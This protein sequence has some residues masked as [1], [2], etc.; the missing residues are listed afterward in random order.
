[1]TS[2]RAIIPDKNDGPQDE[3]MRVV[4]LSFSRLA[5]RNKPLIDI[6]QDLTIMNSQMAVR[7]SIIMN[8]MVSMCVSENRPIPENFMNQTFLYQAFNWR[9]AT[10]LQGIK[11]DTLR[12]AVS[13]RYAYHN[14]DHGVVHPEERFEPPTRILDGQEWLLGYLAGMYAAN[15]TTSIKGK[16]RSV[17]N[18]SIKTYGMTHDL[19]SHDPMLKEIKRQ[20]YNPSRQ[21]PATAPETLPNDAIDLIE[22]HRNGFCMD[23]NDNSP[24]NDEYFENRK[25]Y[26]HFVF[27][28]GRCLERQCELE[29]IHG[30][31]FKKVHPLPMFGM[32]NCV[33]LQID[34]KGMYY[35]LREFERYHRAHGSL[36]LYQQLFAYCLP[37]SKSSFTVEMFAAWVDQLF[38][39]EEVVNGKKQFH[40]KGVI[41]TTDA[42]QVSVHYMK[43]IPPNPNAK[44]KVITNPRAIINAKQRSQRMVRIGMSQTRCD[45]DDVRNGVANIGLDILHDEEFE[46]DEGKMNYTLQYMMYFTQRAF[47]QYESTDTHLYSD[48]TKFYHLYSFIVI[49]AELTSVTFSCAMNMVCCLVHV[50]SHG[51]ITTSKPISMPL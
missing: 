47:L 37:T 13:G 17:I 14:D 5:K 48:S 16:W 8:N 31:E 33:S 50:F 21:A 11:S 45:L 34:K 20:I 3:G 26:H 51:H 40:N 10:N 29:V 12:D 46:H 6:V 18:E 27:H 35:I 4:K 25:L 22:F 43:F 32:G 24:L 42:V 2:S 39:I 1:M 38:R 7:G 19:N 30:R 23:D 41:L 36:D 44:K 15:I 9:L 28:F 49:Q